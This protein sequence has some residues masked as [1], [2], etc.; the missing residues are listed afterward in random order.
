MIGF[1][2]D[3]LKNY[4]LAIQTYDIV[5]NRTVN[6]NEFDPQFI[7]KRKNYIRVLFAKGRCLMQ[8]DLDMQDAMP[9]ALGT[10]QI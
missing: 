4:K 10:F 6:L 2:H 8:P 1:A 9:T 3:S 5:L 7:Q